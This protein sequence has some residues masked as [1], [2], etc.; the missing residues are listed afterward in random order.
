MKTYSFSVEQV[1]L[2]H[3]TTPRRRTTRHHTPKKMFNQ[4]ANHRYP[5]PTHKVGLLQQHPQKPTTVIQ[6]L[7]HL[8]VRP[9]FVLKNCALICGG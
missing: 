9:H 5:T 6:R 4:F 8:K 7:Q 1:T 3:H 2:R